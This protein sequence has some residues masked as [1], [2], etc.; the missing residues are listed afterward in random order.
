M[1]AN[2]VW[3]TNESLILK[4]HEWYLGNVSLTVQDI[5]MIPPLLFRTQLADQVQGLHARARIC[6]HVCDCYKSEAACYYYLSLQTNWLLLIQ[7]IKTS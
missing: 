2:V 7:I 6:V 1:L 5:W 3:L 4:M